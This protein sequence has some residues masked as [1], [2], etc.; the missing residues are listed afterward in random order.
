MEQ[1][2][3]MSVYYINP[4]GLSPTGSVIEAQASEEYDDI[5]IGGAQLHLP[6]ALGTLYCS[7]IRNEEL[8]LHEITSAHHQR[9]LL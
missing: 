2:E 4:S 5:K 6:T 3:E 1:Y 9:H 7:F 8:M